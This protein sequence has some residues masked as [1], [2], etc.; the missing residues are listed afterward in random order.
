MNND[1]FEGV[2]FDNINKYW[3]SDEY[4]SSDMK[5]CII[6]QDPISSELNNIKNEI[7]ASKSKGIIKNLKGMIGMKRLR[8][9]WVKIKKF[10]C[11]VL[12]IRTKVQ[13]EIIAKDAATLE[14]VKAKYDLS[15]IQDVLE[16]DMFLETKD[17]L[18][19]SLGAYYR[20]LVKDIKI[21]IKYYEVKKLEEIKN[22]NLDEETAKLVYSKT[23]EYLNEKHIELVKEV[24]ELDN[25]EVTETEIK[26]DK[27]KLVP[28]RYSFASVLP[29]ID[30]SKDSLAYTK[31]VN[32]IVNKKYGLNL[33]C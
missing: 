32:E 25:I 26:E 18:K 9:G 3:E 6:K 17:E 13:K 14:I 5:K 20:T 24:N 16:Y 2:S 30:L 10:V 12:G 19:I 4:K 28:K 23:L 29:D 31:L 15:R 11:K 1:F 7:N 22:G 8:E 33:E 27:I 21:S